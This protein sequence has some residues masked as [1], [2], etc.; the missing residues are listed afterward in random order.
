MKG[1]VAAVILASVACSAGAASASQ[2][3][4]QPGPLCRLHEFSWGFGYHDYRAEW[5]TEDEDVR[6][7]NLTQR[8]YW[9]Q[10]YYTFTENWTFYSRFGVANLK[11]DT[12]FTQLDPPKDYEADYGFNLTLGVNGLLYRAP[13]WGIGP[14]LQAN[15]YADYE[16]ELD[17]MLRE[18]LGGGEAGILAR[19]KGWRDINLG[20]A[21]QVDVGPLVL[22]GGG[23]GYWTTADGHVEITPLGENPQRHQATVDERGNFG[24]YLGTRIPMGRSWSFHVEGQYKSDLSFSVAISQKLSACFD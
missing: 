9:I 11:I 12:L 23:F 8:N 3:L 15:F 16:T 22:Y 18:D 14:I 7:G 6:T 2:D 5:Q 21:A 10:V 24:G 4:G 19:F 17:G 1:L 20:I 13:G